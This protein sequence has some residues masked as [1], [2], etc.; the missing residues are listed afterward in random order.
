MTEKIMVQIQQI[1][2]SASQALARSHRIRMD[3]PSIKGGRDAGPMGGEL[4][5]AGLGGCFMSNLLAAATARGVSLAETVLEISGTLADAPARYTAVE[6]QITIAGVDRTTAEK[7]IAIAEKGCMVA[8]TLK[9]ALTLTLQVNLEA[10][11]QT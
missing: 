7:L 10:G 6:M 9:A 2:A 3:R 11:H 1:S 4:L 5:L 8:N